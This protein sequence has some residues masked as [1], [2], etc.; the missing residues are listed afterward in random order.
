MDKRIVLTGVGVLASNAKGKEAYWEALREGRT[1]IKPI[2]LFDTAEFAVNMA[3]EVQDFE[4]KKYF[5]PKGLRS[6]DRS[7]KLLVSASKLAIADSGFT[8]TDENTDDVGVSVGT[9][10]G[11]LKSISEFDEVTLKEGPRYTN[12]AHFPNTVINS[13]ASQVSI[14]NNIQGFNT[15]ISTG[16]TASM[17]AM[18]YAFDAIQTE[19]AK[20]VYTGGVEELCYP[21][22]YGFYALKFL[23]GSNG[24][25][26]FINCPY[27]RRRNGIAFGEGAVLIAMEELEHARKR[28]A[29][30][31]GEVLGFGYY[32]DTFRIN[33]YNPRGTGVIESMRNALTDAG[34]GPE[35][36]DYICS[37]ANSTKMADKIETAAIKEVFGK[38]AYNIPVSSVKSMV[39]ECYSVSGALAVAGCLGA[40]NGE[41]VP[42]TVNLKERDPDCDLDYVPQKAQKAAID[43]ALI[44][45]FG[46]N[47]SHCCMVLGKYHE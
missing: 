46:P 16:F 7:T 4:P 25:G 30:I 1:G 47:G 17:D 12:P 36:I 15:T 10:L 3:G 29:K 5:G 19:R 45:N 32:F 31:L 28:Q 21:T 24:G 22:Y 38:R 8:I 9:T 34:V 33:K 41:F 35:A 42:P 37:N 13:P 43:K 20:L 11:S 18:N 27:D 39:G 23:S 6:L 40:I 44:V 26:A 2:S 14:W